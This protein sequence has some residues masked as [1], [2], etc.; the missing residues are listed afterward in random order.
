MPRARNAAPQR[1]DNHVLTDDE[2]ADLQ[3][4]YSIKIR[5][6]QAI[7]A[8]KKAVAD[9]ARTDVNNLFAL[10]KG[11]LQISRKDFEE[12]L[13]LQD[14]NEAEFI[15]HEK[16]RTKRM[17]AQ[18]LPVGTQLDM[19]PKADTV[20]DLGLAQASG[21]RAGLRGADPEVPERFAGVTHQAWMEGWHEG[22]AENIAKL[23]R[24][25]TILDA[26]KAQ[27]EE[28]EAEGD[29]EED[30]FDADA[31]ARALRK[32]GFMDTTGADEE[33]AAPEMEA[34]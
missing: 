13:A 15:E 7:H 23:G 16:K 34:A 6:A 11:D 10:V 31:E 12:I 24:A 32:S 30:E 27:A 26:R 9:A 17:V 5:G 1:D 33:Q 21:K 4:Y 18:G 22:Q 2:I 8:E 14:M 3:H 19:F 28:P 29:E 20:D 25:Q